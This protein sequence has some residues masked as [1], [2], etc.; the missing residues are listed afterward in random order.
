M[1]QR[2]DHEWFRKASIW[3]RFVAKIVKDAIVSERLPILVVTSSL[4][5]SLLLYKRY[6]VGRQVLMVV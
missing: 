1:A 2:L 3:R 4:R 6:V 5:V